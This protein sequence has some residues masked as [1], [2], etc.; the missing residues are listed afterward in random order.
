M[1]GHQIKTKWLQGETAVVGWSLIGHPEVSN[2]LA[3]ANVDG[4]VLDW[5]HGIDLNER[6]LVDCIQ[7][8]CTQHGVA[9]LVRV[10]SANRYQISHVLDAGACGILVAMVNTPE[11]AERAGRACRYA[12]AG[13]R[14]LGSA[15]HQR[16]DESINEYV[17]R[18]NNE[19]ICVVMI[20]TK[21]GVD[22][23]EKIC[24]APGVDGV[25]IGPYDLSLDMGI[26]TEDFVD[27]PEHLN[28]VKRVFTAARNQ[29][30]ATGHHGFEINDSITWAKMGSMLCQI[31]SDT[32][33][34]KEQAQHNVDIFKSGIK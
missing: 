23:I 29:G 11:D 9:P 3:R 13:D 17:Q 27:H 33:F 16:Q 34:L 2:V 28:V 20:E 10:P 4:V 26:S 22:N 32:S 1:N 24:A 30:I 6:S 14:S 12:P 15:P 7:S 25:Y 8:I 21:E 31:G 19:I 18:A 5:Q